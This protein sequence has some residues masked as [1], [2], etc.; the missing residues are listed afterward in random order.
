MFECEYDTDL[1]E[2]ETIA[3][4]M[5]NYQQVLEWLVAQPGAL[6]ERF[7]LSDAL[8]ERR[9]RQ[10][11]VAVSA[12]F[13][14]EPMVPVL[15]YWMRAFRIPVRLAFTPHDQVFQQ[16][17]DPA[18]ETATNRNGLNLILIRFEDW[19]RETDA[20]SNEIERTLDDFIAGL[21]AAA[22]RT[23]TPFLVLLCPDSPAF[24]QAFPGG[25]GIEAWTRRLRTGTAGIAGVSFLAHDDW[26]TRYPVPD[27]YDGASDALGRVP[28]TSAFFSALATVAAREMFAA[29]H[30]PYKVIALDCDDTLWLGVCGEGPVSLDSGRL[31]LQRV[32]ASQRDAG[33]ILVLCSKNEEADV[34]AV[35]EEHP[36]MPL[37]WD[38]FVTHRINWRPKSANLA[39][40]AVELGLGRDS[41]VFI[42]DSP[43]EI[44]EVRGAYPE[45]LSLRLPR[46]S[47]EIRAFTD[48]C[49]AFDRE[50]ATREDRTRSKLYR[51]NKDRERFRSRAPSFADFIAGLELHIEIAPMTEGQ[52]VRCAQLTRRT[53]QFN[54]TTIRQTERELIAFAARDDAACLTVTVRDRFGD[55]GLTGLVCYTERATSLRITALMLSCRVLGRG[56]EHA[57]IAHLGKTARRLGKTAVVAMFRTTARNRPVRDFLEA[58]AADF[59]QSAAAE[60]GY[61]I[62]V[63]HAERLVFEPPQTGP[64]PETS[65]RQERNER[66]ATHEAAFRSV[67]L[68]RIATERLTPLE[69]WQRVRAETR[70]RRPVNRGYAPPRNPTEKVLTDLFAEILPLDQV[71]VHDDFFALGGHSL[72]GVQLLSRIRS[73]LGATLSLRTLFENPDPASL[74]IRVEGQGRAVT[75]PIP[76]APGG[77]H[78]SSSQRRLWLQTHL[79]GSR[80]AYNTP[81]AIRIRGPLNLRIW[82]MVFGEIVR[83]HEPTRTIFRERN[84]EPIAEVLA[85]GP[86]PIVADLRG[87]TDA[88]RA[89][90]TLVWIKQAASFAFSP[91][92]GPFFRLCVF[93]LDRDEHLAVLLLH[94]LITDGWSMG[95]LIREINGLY[96][97]LSLGKDS[98]FAALTA[99]YS[100]AV[101]WQANRHGAKQ[102][103]NQTAV[104]LARLADAPVLMTLPTDFARPPVRGFA[105]GSVPIA[106]NEALSDSLTRLSR[107]RGATPFMSLLAGFAV[108]LQRYS[109]Q[110]DLVIGT[111]T[112]NR[113]H[114]QIEQM[115]GLFADTAALRLELS[116]DA[117][118][119]SLLDQ[120]RERVLEADANSGLS[121]EAIVEALKP[122]RDPS[123]HPVFQT[124]IAL[125]T[126]MDPFSLPGLQIAPVPL[127]TVTAKF[128]LSLLLEQGPD[129]IAG[130]IEYRADLFRATTVRRMAAHL[131]NAL[132]SISQDPNQIPARIGLLSEAERRRILVDWNRTE[133]PF[134]REARLE[135]LFEARAVSDPDAIAIQC[136]G[137]E[138]DPARHLSYAVLNRR[139]NQIARDLRARGAKPGAA[140]AVYLERSPDLI[141]C[142]LGV[143]KSGSYYAPIETGYPAG[144]VKSILEASGAR[145]CLAAPS[146]HA[147]VGGADVLPID[148]RTIARQSDHEPNRGLDAG[149]PAYLIF[150]SGSTGKPKG[151]LVA[152][153]PVVNLI[154]WVNRRFQVDG[155]DRLL[156]VTSPCFDLSVYDV[157]GCL[158]AGVC[159]RIATEPELAEP[160]T[161]A[162]I[163]IREAITFWDSAPAALERLTYFFATR[164]SSGNALKRVFL[165]GDWIPLNLPDI[166]RQT[167]PNARVIGLGGTTET[168]VWSN[169]F[170]IGALE[171]EW[172]SIPYGRP[173]Q[174]TRISVLDRYLAP[175]PIGVPGQ[176]HFA[177]GC[178]AI[179]YVNR[180][181]ATASRFLP[182]P[183]SATPGSRRYATGDL[184]RYFPDGQLEFLGRTDRQIK[185]RGYRIELGE[186]ETAL[187]RWPAVENAVVADYEDGFGARRLAAYIVAKQGAAVDTDALRAFI[188]DLLPGYMLPSA[189]VALDSVPLSPNGKLDRDRLPAP[190]PLDGNAETGS[191]PVQEMLSLVW[192]EALGVRVT[193]GPI[194]ASFFELG[195][196]SLSAARVTARIRDLFGVDLAMR[197]FFR[198]PTI[199]AL[200][201]KIEASRGKPNYQAIVAP[202]RPARIPLSFNQNRLWVTE[203]LGGTGDAYHLPASFRV[204]GPID[205][206]MLGRCWR[207]LVQTHEILRTSFKQEGETAFQF[208]HPAPGPGLALVD[209]KDLANRRDETASLTARITGTPFALTRPPIRMVLIRIEREE[210]L[211]VAVV[212]HLIADGWSVALLIR[213]LSERYAAA[214]SAKA[215]DGGRGS[216]AYADYA[217]WQRAREADYLTASDR[218]FWLK[219][220][221]DMPLQLTLPVDSAP[222]RRAPNASGQVLAFRIEPRIWRRV[223]QLGGRLA[224]TPFMLLESVFAVLLARYSGQDDIAVGFPAANRARPELSHAIGF[225][226][227]TLVLRN[228]LSGNPGFAEL[229]TRVRANALAAYDHQEDPF[230]LVLETVKPERIQG[231][232]PL[233]RV[234]FAWQEA[235]MVALRLRGA[236]AH[237]E[238]V[239]PTAAKFDLTLALE[240]DDQGL[241]GQFEYDA[242]LFEQSAIERM[243]RHYRNLLVAI[244]GDPDLPIWDLALLDEAERRRILVDWNEGRPEAC[245][246]VC[247]HQLFEAQAP[248]SPDAIAL[249][250][251]DAISGSVCLSYATLDRSADGWARHLAEL[252]VGPDSLTGL[253]GEVEPELLIGMLAILKAGGAYL[254]LDPSTPRER[255]EWIVNN[256]GL[257][258]AFVLDAGP[259]SGTAVR[260]VTPRADGQIVRAKPPIT[261]QNRVDPQN[262]AYA[263]YTSGSTGTPKGVGVTHTGSVS[264][265]LAV[266]RRFGLGP[267]DRVLRFASIG[268]DV[269][270]EEI[271]PTFAFGACLQLGY[272]RR[273]VPLAEFERFLARSAI[274]VANLPAS[275]WHEWVR[276]LSD[277][278]SAPARLPRLIVT[279]SERVS[280]D[281]FEEWRRLVGERITWLNAYGPSETTVTATLFEPESNENTARLES[282]PLGLALAN[283]R[284]FIHDARFWPVPVGVAGELII[285]GAGLARGYLSDPAQ[286]AFRFVPDPSAV[287]PGERCYK[288]GDRVRF[289]QDGVILFLGRIDFQVKV[290]GFRIELEEI[291]Q[292]LLTHPLVEKAVVTAHE[293]TPDAPTLI[294]YIQVKPER[295][296]VTHAEIRTFLAR[297]LPRYMT[298]AALVLMDKLPLTVGGKIDRGALPEPDDVKQKGSGGENPPRTDNE[299]ALARIWAEV[300]GLKKVDIFTN[301]FELGGDSILALRIAGRAARSGLCFEPRDLFRNPTIAELARVATP[302]SRPLTAAGPVSGPVP[303]APIQHW[304]FN[305]GFPNPNHYNQSAFLEIESGAPALWVQAVLDRLVAQHAQLRA[306]FEREA[307]GWRQTLAS[308]APPV[309][310]HV[311]NLEEL[312]CGGDKAVATMAVRV[313]TGLNLAKGPLM[314]AVLFRD[315]VSPHD[316]LLIVIHHLVIDAVSWRILLED[317]SEFYGEL[318]TNRAS[319][320]RSPTSAYRD[321]TSAMTRFANSPVGQ[322][323]HAFWRDLPLA[324]TLPRE[325]HAPHDENR[326]GNS[327]FVE[328][329][330]DRDRTRDLLTEPAR[331]YRLKT[332][333]LMLAALARTLARWLDAGPIAIDVESHGRFAP[334]DADALDL[335]HTV[336]WFTAVFPMILNGR[337]TNDEELLIAV[338]ENGRRTPNHGIGHAALRYV[339]PDPEVRAQLEQR[340]RAEVLFN[341]LGRL[342]V[343]AARPFSGR[344]LTPPGPEQ[345][346]AAKRGHLL[347]ISAA[348][349]ENQLRIRWRYSPRVHARSTI[350]ELAKRFV[351]DLEGLLQ[352]CAATRRTRPTPSDFPLADLDRTRLDRILSQYPRLEDIYPLSPLQHGLL[353]HALDPDSPDL[354]FEQIACLIRGPLQEG[355]LKR[356][357]RATIA[358][359]P[360]LRTS[361]LWRDLTQPLQIVQTRA[362]IVW[363]EEDWSSIL[364]AEQGHALEALLAADRARGFRLETGPLMRCA[365]IRTGAD[366]YRFIWSHHHLILDGWSA[367]ILL[368]EVFVRYH[369]LTGAAGPVEPNSAR[370]NPRPFRDFIA[371]LTKQDAARAESFL[372]EPVRR[373]PIRRTHS[374]SFPSIAFPI[375]TGPTIFFWTN[376]RPS[377][378]APTPDGWASRSTHYFKRR[379]PNCS[380]SIPAT[381]IFCSGPRVSGR[382]PVYARSGIDGRA[383]DQHDSGPDPARAGNADRLMV[384]PNPR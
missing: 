360:V 208:I 219:Y 329:S 294:A 156:F 84:G 17:L 202:P 22:S 147:I 226:A 272:A 81:T 30:P 12:T 180:P 135:H 368:K 362:P 101:F 371:G 306:R 280:P 154:E 270:A 213:T 316:R 15:D 133:A 115:I 230:D 384:D 23:T 65:S 93:R 331:A 247:L 21:A 220:L 222:S 333:E 153:R 367:A 205:A 86:S 57:M 223:L 295:D 260:L 308:D 357:W 352:H 94:H 304:F 211:L 363:R 83:R 167:F 132:V 324:Q 339:H 144:R 209:L 18:S 285:A 332:D 99:T 279:G 107:E 50:T 13:T 7:P 237:T 299:R 95:L 62:P 182:D 251:E 51:E 71:G 293:K 68:D 309:P 2:P 356:A 27:F 291:E 66:P 370:S 326:H 335:S 159:L 351:D 105:G 186:V 38:D 124:V 130:V 172:R 45:I 241:I 215:A 353:F 63:E 243:A 191:G 269:A 289:R 188:G 56:V 296:P 35:F 239:P 200:A 109:G 344:I 55:H 298:P 345:D 334:T 273:S 85:Q 229:A 24:A 322:A 194:N 110:D 158:A 193:T 155:D 43:L 89:A 338:K 337:E 380:R 244:I 313:Q 379:G 41:F 145:L 67:L 189:F 254:P 128:D 113:G 16:L 198:D 221:A 134:A 26:R 278:D 366:A 225:F 210:H 319:E 6:L 33:M 117:P 307:N 146:R 49:W 195:G 312:D 342:D 74:A 347:E 253:M 206:A 179:G 268:F 174:N 248:R 9:N 290:R 349:T 378:C 321:W 242:E 114:E 181:R 183:N 160:E 138:T 39:E 152:H 119:T 98:P 266:G 123:R 53:N 31:A 42:D 201:L 267:A 136:P 187:K 32:L 19:R 302:V 29:H 204:D 178:F 255:L 165:S 288:T 25:S 218:D 232:N 40:I 103:A 259:W 177:G 44:A 82:A 373:A 365:L 252:G 8:F 364:P 310:L 262:L 76:P 318:A 283:T 330:L 341:Y 207:H 374:P 90:Q 281:L 127:P 34:R 122:G 47:R 257:A 261:R 282:M 139:A 376:K 36:E 300:L 75:A 48:H 61:A 5:A 121:F 64:E 238:P 148:P 58:I 131:L 305:Q 271:H 142:L 343:A 170:V 157:F 125:N 214:L 73:R 126:R 303:L 77:P 46:P 369:D 383:P 97:A 150:T 185:V 348:V 199:A 54:T 108:L 340:S 162:R 354:Y 59:K 79:D 96:P 161:L 20:A 317:F 4:F 217:V 323:E 246:P 171:P 184:V 190:R 274:T 320:P 361:F 377:V 227:N 216:L 284:T 196:H 212:H 328:C 88:D 263:V 197:D 70:R 143:L 264:H 149:Q 176:L 91:E 141:A 112:A 60:T 277:A 140:V 11:T 358:A 346:P 327:A 287:K 382:S 311:F 52:A 14:A 169:Y 258:V 104:W 72:T 100:D 325:D 106:L 249:R 92:Q 276:R 192:A 80:L 235:P 203:K 37:A 116:N 350:E 265:V 129:G 224:A 381:A 151:V 245:P 102:R 137:G 301:F 231:Q 118:I 111:P 164:G 336:G 236:R 297:K 256:A 375:A 314:R 69:V 175:A 292:V 10:R 78:L 315:R 233:F 234:M 250:H 228:D 87:L 275:F 120:I 359:H 355:A 286:T 372:A 28:Y 1:F 240:P 163:L 168:V 166:V 3:A 173:I